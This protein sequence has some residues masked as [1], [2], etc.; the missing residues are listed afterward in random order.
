MKSCWARTFKLLRSPGI[1]SKES[2]P[3]LLKIYKFRLCSLCSLLCISPKG[4]GDGVHFFVMSHSLTVKESFVVLLSSSAYFPAEWPVVQKNTYF[5]HFRGVH[6]VQNRRYLLIVYIFFYWTSNFFC[7]N[8]K[9]GNLFSH[10]LPVAKQLRLS[11]HRDWK[12][13]L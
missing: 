10:L 8:L 7:Q 5:T 13:D 11:S 12:R 2:L 3:V 6:L 1:V 9:A 4:E